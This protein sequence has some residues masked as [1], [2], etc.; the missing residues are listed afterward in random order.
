M[1]QPY[2]ESIAHS[3]YNVEESQEFFVFDRLRKVTSSA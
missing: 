3:D 2:I 1:C